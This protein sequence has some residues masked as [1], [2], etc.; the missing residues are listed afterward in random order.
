MVLPTAEP[1]S[2]S[3]FG[4]KISSAT[5][6]RTI[7][8]YQCSPGIT[9]SLHF[10]LERLQTRAAIRS[11]ISYCH[12]SR[13]V[14]PASLSITQLTPNAGYIGYLPWRPSCPLDLTRTWPCGVAYGAHGANPAPVHHALTW[15][16]PGATFLDESTRQ[17]AR[18]TTAPAALSAA[19]VL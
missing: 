3:R 2:G 13:H 1:I 11:I 6:T 4:P 18:L 10:W 19:T 12:A 7:R 17:V 16:Y 14:L 9:E 8:S 15:R 5:T